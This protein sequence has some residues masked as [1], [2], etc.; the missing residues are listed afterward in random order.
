MLNYNPI[1]VTKYDS[2]PVLRQAVEVEDDVTSYVPVPTWIT[3]QDDKWIVIDKTGVHEQYIIQDKFLD[4]YRSDFDKMF[5]ELV[6][7]YP[8]KVGSPGRGDRILRAKDPNAVS[9]KKAKIKYK[10]LVDGRP[11]V[12]KYIIKCLQIQLQHEKGNLG[13]MQNLETWINN[14]TWEKYE[15]ININTNTDDGRI[16]RK[17]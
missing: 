14:H 11:H 1:K 13:Y 9:N 3:F 5:E 15:D 2:F 7:L 4:L 17:L 10:R 6:E 8:F 16:T 12:H